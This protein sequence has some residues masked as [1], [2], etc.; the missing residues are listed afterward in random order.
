MNKHVTVACLHITPNDKK[1][2]KQSLYKP[3][4][5]SSAPLRARSV[6]SFIYSASRLTAQAFYPPSSLRSDGT[7]SNDGLHELAAPRWYS[8]LIAQR[9]VVSYTTFSPLPHQGAAVV[10]FYRHLPSPTASTFGSGVPYAARTFLSRH[11]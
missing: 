1:D 3:G 7:P 6:L 9:L 4:S 11:N 10:L 8:S 2:W 5:V